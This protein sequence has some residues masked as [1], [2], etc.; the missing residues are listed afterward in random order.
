MAC[1]V[2]SSVTVCYRE[3]E[4][5]HT[6]THRSAVNNLSPLQWKLLALLCKPDFLE[7]VKRHIT[8]KEKKR[9]HT[10]QRRLQFSVEADGRLITL[11]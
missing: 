9:R 2:G 5:T 10:A 1:L 11:T 6:Q 3:A 7:A 4:H 8:Q